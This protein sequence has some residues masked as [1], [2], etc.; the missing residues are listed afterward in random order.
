VEIN[1]NITTAAWLT[2]WLSNS[3]ARKVQTNTLQSYTDLINLYI[4]PKI[5]Q[6][7]VKELKTYHIQN[8]YDKMLKSGLG[9]R[10]VR[11][12]HSV[13]NTGL[14]NAVN[15]ELLSINPCDRCELPKLAKK[16][17]EY[18]TLNQ[19][20]QFIEACREVENGLLCELLLLTGLRP[21]EALALRWTDID[22][23]NLTISI[24]RKVI[25]K[26]NGAGGYEFN[27][28][29]TAKSARMLPVEQDLLT[30]LLKHKKEQNKFILQ[31]G[32]KYKRLGLIF[33]SESGTPIQQR[34]FRRRTFTKI[35]EKAGI[36]SAITPYSLRHSFAS[37][38]LQNGENLKVIGDYLG[39]SSIT[40]T[41]DTYSHVTPVMK[42]SASENLNLLFK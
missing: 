3:V 6:I 8:V 17:K 31:K 19:A 10:T 30:R 12:A 40:I 20:K 7:K 33:A 2:Y 37:L 16:E 39:H 32:E 38:M 4:I 34:N 35:L 1:G 22:T 18:L 5:G 23:N 42:R 36:T 25:Y 14:K 13:L 28:T 21:S 24:Q 11:Y 41:A 15:S 29:K 27:K 9:S 26:L